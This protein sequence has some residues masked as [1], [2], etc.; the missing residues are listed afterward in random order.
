MRIAIKATNLDLTPA[1]KNY[2]E[3]KIG[4]LEKYLDKVIEAKVELERDRKHNTGAVFRAE[5]MIV[6]QG[7]VLRAE[8]KSEDMY[9]AI[10]MVVPKLREQISKLKNRKSTLIKRGARKAKSENR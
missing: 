5:V 3:E 8:E 2:A 1:L 7:K 6:I 4:N 10:D 9:S